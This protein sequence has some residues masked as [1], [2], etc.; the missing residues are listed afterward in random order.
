V[1][2]WRWHGFFKAKGSARKDGSIAP[3]F[4][5]PVKIAFHVKNLHTRISKNRRIRKMGDSNFER[6]TIEP[7][8]PA[9]PHANVMQLFQFDYSNPKAILH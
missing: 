8:R 4:F 2:F 9:D 6:A 1:R 5:A 7:S 3:N